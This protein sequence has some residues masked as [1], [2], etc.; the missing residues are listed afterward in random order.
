MEAFLDKDGRIKSY[1]SRLRQEGLIATANYSRNA[2]IYGVDLDGEDRHGRLSSY[3]HAGEYGFGKKNRGVILGSRLAAK[4]KVE[5]GKKIVLSAQ[6]SENDVSAISL[7]VTGILKTNNMGLDE[8][9]VYIHIDKARE[10]LNVPEG[11]SQISVL[12]ADK[13]DVAAVQKQLAAHLKELD[14]LSWDQLYPALFQGREMMEV[15][16]L[17]NEGQGL[18][19]AGRHEH[20]AGREDDERAEREIGDED[21]DEQADAQ[22]QQ[23]DGEPGKRAATRVPAVD[24]HIRLAR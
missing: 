22:H 6:N 9:A 8:T 16:N 23:E 20:E 4:M 12:V 11:A 5:V 3:L 2:A 13:E 7:R 24:A 10:L 18:G 19:E 15:F 14:V 17:H 1:V 21:L